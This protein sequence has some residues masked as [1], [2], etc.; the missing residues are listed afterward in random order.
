MEPIGRLLVNG[1]TAYWS[2]GFLASEPLLEFQYGRLEERLVGGIR[3]ILLGVAQGFPI[4]RASAR[5][6][7]E[8]PLLRRPSAGN[9]IPSDSGL[10]S[11]MA[12][13]Q[14]RRLP[15]LDERGALLGI[16]SLSDVARE[17]EREMTEAQPEI[18]EMEVRG[19]LAA[20]CHRTA[21]TLAV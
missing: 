1:R 8:S 16:V 19:T 2:P 7:L 4:A 10:G 18:S 5:A 11:V 9:S 3:C 12:Q 13:A 15:V 20:I 21:N 6:T 14:V 17:A